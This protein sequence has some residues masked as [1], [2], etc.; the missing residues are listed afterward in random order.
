MYCPL[1]LIDVGVPRPRGSPSRPEN[2]GCPRRDPSQ[3]PAGGGA[4]SSGAASAYAA[5]GSGRIICVGGPRGTRSGPAGTRGGRSLRPSVARALRGRERE[6]RR[7]ARSRGRRWR[8]RR[9]R[10]HGLDLGPG[11]LREAHHRHAGSRPPVP[12]QPGGHRPPRRPRLHLP[13][14]VRASRSHLLHQGAA[15]LPPAPRHLRERSLGASPGVPRLPARRPRREAALR[16]PEARP[17]GALPSGSPGLPGRQD[18]ADRHARPRGHGLVPEGHGLRT[19]RGPGRDL[20]RTPCRGLVGGLQRLGSRPSPRRAAALSRRPRRGVRLRLSRARPGTLP[21]PR[22]A[23]RPG[24]GTRWLR[25]VV[26]GPTAGPRQP[27]GPR[28]QRRGVRRPALRPTRR[29]HLAVP[30]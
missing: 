13:R 6:G 30:A 24:R 25:T 3:A 18:R 14:R 17:R 27:P 20:G 4:V 15:R 23:A 2:A 9:A 16:H 26:A 7:V 21:R 19:R 8:A 28:A 22:L 5:G 10:A 12:A 1:Y 29:R 11:A